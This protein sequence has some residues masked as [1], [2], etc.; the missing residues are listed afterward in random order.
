MVVQSTPINEYTEFGPF[1]WHRIPSLWLTML[2]IGTVH[3][4]QLL[5]YRR[6]SIVGQHLHN[7]IDIRFKRF[8]VHLQSPSIV[9]GT[10]EQMLIKIAIFAIDNL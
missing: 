3:F 8:G 1:R 10:N 6:L 7:Q 9:F 2:I 5:D 4:N